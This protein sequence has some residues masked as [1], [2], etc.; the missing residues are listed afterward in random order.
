[1][2]KTQCVFAQSDHL[3]LVSS[4]ISS[5]VLSVLPTDG[6]IHDVLQVL[7]EG[8]SQLELYSVHG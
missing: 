7:L 3:G 6:R 8:F 5:I 2:A 4:S 1:M